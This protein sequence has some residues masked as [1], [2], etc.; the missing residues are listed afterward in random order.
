MFDVLRT[1]FEWDE[2]KI[3]LTVVNMELASRMLSKYLVTHLL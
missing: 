2:N 1:K 3:R